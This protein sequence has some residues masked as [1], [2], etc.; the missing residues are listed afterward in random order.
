MIKDAAGIKNPMGRKLLAWYKHHQ[1]SLPWRKTNDPYRIWISEI[2]LQQTQ[3]NTVIPY[4]QRFIKSF[5]DVRTLAAATLQDVLKAWENMGYY[6][7]ARNIHAASRIIV[8]QWG[9]RIP[10]KFE[11]IKTIPGIGEYTA[12]A[13]L[14][15]AYRQ[16]VPAVDG[17]VRRIMS[18]LFAIHKPVDD[19]REQKNLRDLAALLVPAKHPGEFNQGLMDLGA[20]VCRAKN[21]DCSRCPLTGLCRAKL[22]N[23][24]NILPITRKTPAILHRQA[25]A[26]IIRNSENLLLVV[27]RPA[28]GLLASLWKLPGGFIED[29]E[30]TGS[31]LRRNVKEEL[32]ISI[33]VGRCLASVDH[34]YSHFRLTLQA[35]ECRLL[36]GDPEA[37]AC[38]NWR[39][40]TSAQLKNLPMSNIDRKILAEIAKSSSLS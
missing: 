16:C 22:H 21:P 34:A 29:V 20:T 40:A 36:K 5:P 23:L 32:N 17:N 10:D 18:R 9:G 3:V 39:W 12:G 11:E 2:M 6:S 24:Q 38:Q 7:R 26:A 35:Y 13:I 4:Y 31:L 15:I 28:S 30:K 33:R 27:Q 19:P 37:M 25:A 14:S 8:N 1:R